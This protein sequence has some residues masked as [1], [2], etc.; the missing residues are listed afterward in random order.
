[1]E[2]TSNAAPQDASAARMVDVFRPGSLASD[3]RDLMV[4]Y[5][6]TASCPSK[7]DLDLWA[8]APCRLQI[9]IGPVDPATL[10][11]RVVPTLHDGGWELP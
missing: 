6:D 7:L 4:R 1:M 2:A 8:C 9:S 11:L 5:S 3:C 10:S